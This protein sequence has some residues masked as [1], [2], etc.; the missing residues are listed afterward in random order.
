MGDPRGRKGIYET[1]ILWFHSLCILRSMRSPKNVK[2]FIA[3]DNNISPFPERHS[4]L[5][6]SPKTQSKLVDSG[7][8][9]EPVI[10]VTYRGEEKQFK[11][12]SREFHLKTS[13]RL[14]RHL[15]FHQ[16]APTIRETVFNHLIANGIKPGTEGWHCYE[17]G[18][19]STSN[20][21]RDVEDMH[22]DIERLIY[23]VHRDVAERYEGVGDEPNDEAKKFYKLVEDGKQELYPGC[24]KNSK[25]S[26]LIRFYLLKCTH[27]LTN[28]EISDFLELFREVLPDASNLPNSFNEA[29]RLIKDLGLHY[30]KID[31]CRNDYM[32]YW[33][34]HEAATSCHVCHAPR[35]KETQTENQ[36]DI[37]NQPS[38]KVH[39]VPAKV[40]WHFPLKPRLQRL[41]MCSETAELMRWHDEERKKDEL[42]RH[43]ADGEAWK[44]FD[45]KYPEFA[46]ETRNVHLGLASDGFNPFRTMST[47]HSTWPVVLI[48]YNLPPWLCMKPEFLMLSLLIPGPTSPGND[49]DVFLQPLIQELKDLWEYGL[50]TYDAE[51]RQ[52]FKMH[53]ALQ[54]TTSD[55]P[56]YAMLSGWITK[57]KYAC[58]YCHYETD[59]HH[60]S[61]S[62]KSCYWAHRRWLDENHPWR[63]DMKSF[64]GE[65]EERTSPDPLTGDQI[66]SLLENW[67]NKF[68]KLQPKKKYVDCPW[69]KSSVFY[70]L[71][72]WKDCGCRHHLDVMHIEKNVC[73][74][75]LGTL[76]DIPRKS[77]DHHK[78]RLDLQEL[79]IRQ[80][81]HPVDAGDKQYVLLPKASFSMTKEEKSIFCSV[82]KK[83]KL[84][85][86]CA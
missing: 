38:K 51:K 74:N 52:T 21:E 76:L 15:G 81:L 45:Q 19:S 44:E 13:R 60:L 10:V 57:G 65:K 28:I 14:D 73:D 27:G 11:F 29:R 23:D 8:D 37:S 49:I 41:Y 53:A 4:V 85:Q 58:P 18:L 61:N 78:A 84:P 54:S 20:T 55:F 75:V 1:S 32:L 12:N 47:Q 63:H 83:A 6:L 31:A 7:E 43:P 34:E 26:F 16:F 82:L 70:T 86:G 77:K 68:E 35:W 66:S 46:N 36:E 40:L 22:D 25:L 64:N 42:L 17:K 56:G 48:N 2:G 30:D 59:H 62:N 67:E 39:Q 9:E 69:R 24:K 50:D 72:Y 71:P 5:L 80:E 33:K 79:G 3:L